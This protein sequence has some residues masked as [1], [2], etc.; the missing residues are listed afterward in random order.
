MQNKRK[1]KKLTSGDGF[2][3]ANEAPLGLSIGALL[4]ASGGEAAAGGAETEKTSGVGD[5]PHT[6]Q[7]SVHESE[8]SVKKARDGKST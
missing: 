3:L 6:G 4:G 1:N 2:T 5:A 7:P 8:A